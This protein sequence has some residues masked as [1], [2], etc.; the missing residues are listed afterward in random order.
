MK[1]ASLKKH[2]KKVERKWK[3]SKYSVNNVNNEELSKNNEETVK[4][5]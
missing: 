3:K 2:Q 1:F 5:M 4:T